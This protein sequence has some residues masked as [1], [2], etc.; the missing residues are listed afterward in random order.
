[1]LFEGAYEMWTERPRVR[2][3]RQSCL[4]RARGKVRGKHRKRRERATL[5]GQPNTCAASSRLGLIAIVNV[6][7]SL[8]RRYVMSG[9]SDGQLAF[10]PVRV[11]HPTYI[12]FVARYWMDPEFKAQVDLDPAAALRKEGFD[13]P[14]GTEVTLVQSTGDKLHLVLPDATKR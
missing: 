3:R 13:V 14:E 11:D 12:D 5:A 10:G 9:K 1:M 2:S 8:K 7:Y 6:D 4:V